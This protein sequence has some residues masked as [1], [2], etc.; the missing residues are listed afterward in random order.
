[1]SNEIILDGA[2]YVSAGTASKSFDMTRDY[3]ARLCREKRVNGQRIGK[4]W[5]V[6]E[7]S[8]KEFIVAQRCARALRNGSLS[9]ERIIEYHT[10]RTVPS[11]QTAPAGV[12]QT[13]KTQL[14]RTVS[15][16]KKGTA[17]AASEIMNTP[18]GVA[19]AALQAVHVPLYQITPVLDV[20]HRLIAAL[21]ACCIFFG[22]YAI[23]DPSGLHTN[24]SFMLA[25]AERIHA[26][27][28]HLAA[29]FSHATEMLTAASNASMQALIVVS[30]SAN[31]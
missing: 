26:A 4:N 13:I 22:G 27:T 11:K 20:V 28:D 7:H 17:A 8:L 30:M 2:T 24:V 10:H 29:D 31:H 16:P 12:A 14:E 18:S 9:Q 3:I 15:H 21:C 19:Q 25:R 1:M 6:S 23:L 5:F